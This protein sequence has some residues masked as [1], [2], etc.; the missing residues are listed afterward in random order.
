MK[1]LTSII[2]SEHSP[3]LNQTK[4]W[5]LFPQKPMKQSSSILNSNSIVLHGY[6]S[7]RMLQR[8]YTLVSSAVLDSIN[9]YIDINAESYWTCRN[10]ENNTGTDR[11]PYVCCSTHLFSRMML[12][13]FLVKYQGNAIPRGFPQVHCY[14]GAFYSWSNH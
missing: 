9:P 11:L 7:S 1:K 8:V 5:D 2:P 13:M 4:L 3:W 12:T 14:L 6:L 10:F